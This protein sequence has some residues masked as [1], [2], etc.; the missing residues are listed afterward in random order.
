MHV[1]LGMKLAPKIIFLEVPA[2]NHIANQIGQSLA[3]MELNVLKIPVELVNG[4]PA[5]LYR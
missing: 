3:C 5:Q 2:I 1:V 4:V